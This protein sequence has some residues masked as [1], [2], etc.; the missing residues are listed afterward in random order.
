M[1]ILAKVYRSICWG[2]LSLGLWPTLAGA[3]SRKNNVATSS[4]V[5]VERGVELARKRQCAEALPLLNEHI[6]HVTDKLLKYRAEMALVHCAMHN[7]D[8]KTTVSSLLTLRHDYPEDPEVLYLTAHV[9]LEIAVRASRE[10]AIAAPDSY[11]V[12]ELQAETLESQNKW[13]EAAAIYKKILRDN[14]NLPD[15]HLRLG[16]NLL[17]LPQSPENTR[18]ARREFEMELTI[19]PTNGVAEFWL[20]ELARLDGRLDE[21]ISHFASATKLDPALA[22]PLL[23]LGMIFNSAGRVEEAIGPLERYTKMVPEDPAGHF[24]L[25]KAYALANRK[26]DSARELAVHQQLSEKDQAI[27]TTPRNAEPH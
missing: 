18:D 11:Q 7:K 13:G 10:L 21:A 27:S 2:A 1:N 9:F 26:E 14:P 19:D 25:A 22:V 12:S 20:G 3:Q 4:T 5:L 24:Q 23:G 16:R 8:G 17:A 6:P 15:I